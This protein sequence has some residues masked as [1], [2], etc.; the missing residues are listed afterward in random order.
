VTTIVIPGLAERRTLRLDTRRGE[1]I[2]NAQSFEI[3]VQDAADN[4]SHRSRFPSEQFSDHTS[5][6]YNCH[7]LTFASRRTRISDIEALRT[8]LAHDDLS[9]IHQAD[10]RVGD[11]ILYLSADNDGDIEH[12]GVVVEM[13]QAAGMSLAIPRVWSKWGGGAEVVHMWNACPYNIG[14][15]VFLRLVR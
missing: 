7:G 9:E 6:Y 14:N 1:H 8:I 2:D 3:T 15:V 4:A 13:R 12:S 10:V 11:V 5:P